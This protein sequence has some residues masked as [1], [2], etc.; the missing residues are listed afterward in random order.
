MK[1]MI[2]GTYHSVSSKHLDGYLAEFDYRANRRWQESKLFDR[3]IQAALSTK[4]VTYRE[5]VTGD[6]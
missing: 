5:L 2:L 4:S 1:R 6:S 3:L